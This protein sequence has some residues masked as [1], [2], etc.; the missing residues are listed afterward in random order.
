MKDI[1]EYKKYWEEYE[2]FFVWEKCFMTYDFIFFAIF[3]IEKIFSF[4]VPSL[5]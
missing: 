4:R 1:L 2:V 5:A 3:D